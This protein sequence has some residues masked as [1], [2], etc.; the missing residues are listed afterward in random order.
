M[1]NVI[2]TTTNCI[3][4]HIEQDEPRDGGGAWYRCVA[5]FKIQD[6]DDWENENDKSWDWWL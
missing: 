1:P 5:C 3:H 6:P 4:S 2:Q